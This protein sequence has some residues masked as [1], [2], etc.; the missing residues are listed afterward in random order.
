VVADV[1]ELLGESLRQLLRAG[2]VL[3]ERGQDA[4][5]ERMPQRG[6]DALITDAPI[7]AQE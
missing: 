2:L 7:S 5:A 1:A 3:F 6:D 4:R